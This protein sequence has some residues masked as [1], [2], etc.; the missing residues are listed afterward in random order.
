LTCRCRF[1]Q[2]LFANLG[3]A[4]VR[5]VQECH[6]VEQAELSSQI[7]VKVRERK[8]THGIE[9]LSNFLTSLGVDLEGDFGLLGHGVSAE[10][11]DGEL[12]G[13]LQAVI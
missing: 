9:V 7:E 4:D 8:L 6:Q 11:L 10:A 5:S 3:I 13:R 2:D 1:H 12:P